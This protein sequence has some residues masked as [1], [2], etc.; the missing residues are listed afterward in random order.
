MTTN[1]MTLRRLRQNQHIRDLTQ[2]VQVSRK[3]FIQ[4][5]FVVEGLKQREAITGLH[6]IYRE[7]PQSLLQQV[8]RDL[9]VGIA[10]FILF[11]IPKE[12]GLKG[13][14]YEFA[15]EQI[16]ALKDNFGD[17]IWL[18]LDVCICSITLHGH[19]GIL[20]DAKDRIN[21]LA[22][23]AELGQQAVAFADAGA[24]CLA[25]SGMMD[26][27]V[28]KIRQSLDSA[29]HHDRL[30]MSYCTKFASH[31]YGPFR[32][33]ANS[34]PNNDMVCGLKNRKTYQI[35]YRNIADALLSAKRDALEGADI[36]MV[37]PAMPYLDILYRATQQIHKPWA[38]YQVSG[39]YAAIELLHDQGLINRAAGHMEA[40]YGF[41]RAGAQIIISYAARDF[42]A[43]MEQ[44]EA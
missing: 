31:F 39:E 20:N 9:A 16:K 29:G 15:S 43:F 13:F 34:S 25:P 3:D 22:T 26:S 44:M 8:E 21:G 19:C 4:P 38:T 36:L 42:M 5:L 1:Q 28:A 35:D 32:E 7:T 18:A 11:I 2:D 41:K 37:K 10:K 30:I 14:S 40:W 17:K 12:K 24:D 6:G 23:L 27:A 33:A